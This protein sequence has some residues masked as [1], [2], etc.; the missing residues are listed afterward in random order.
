M[1]TIGHLA[2][3]Y[4]MLP[5]QVL[6]NA[7]TYDIMIQD[8]YSAWERYNNNPNDVSQYKEDDL[9]KLNEKSK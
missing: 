5:S 8:V 1:I 6:A 4:G 9:L 2:K 7:T 3:T